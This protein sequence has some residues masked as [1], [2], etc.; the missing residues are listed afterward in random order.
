[1][2]AGDV[3]M[4]LGADPSLLLAL[5]V[6]L[7]AEITATG[8][9]REH[10]KANARHSS[11]ADVLRRLT[12]EARGLR[13]GPFFRWF[14]ALFRASALLLRLGVSGGDPPADRGGGGS[15]SSFFFT[16]FSRASISVASLSDRADD[17]S[18]ERALDQRRVHLAGQIALREVKR[19]RGK[20]WLRRELARV[21]PTQGSGAA[22][23]R[24][25]GA[26]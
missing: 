24:R 11:V 12:L 8:E 16:G 21:A 13:L 20:T 17:A 19:R 1:M 22:T 3:E 25:Q 5:A 6:L 4:Q 7:C 2:A 18:A 23:Y 26:R 9:V 10:L 15:S 14:L